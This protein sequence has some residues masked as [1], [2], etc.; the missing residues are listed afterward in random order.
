MATYTI[1]SYS[2]GAKNPRMDVT[3]DEFKTFTRVWAKVHG[4]IEI[5]AVF[6]K[7]GNGLNYLF[8]GCI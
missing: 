5:K 8:R 7:D 1:E 2:S 6:D 3:E 4:D